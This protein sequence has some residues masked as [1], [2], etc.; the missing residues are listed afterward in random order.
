M[1]AKDQVKSILEQMS[2]D[3]TIEDIQY[4][5]YVIQTVERRLVEAETTEGVPHDAVKA[6][7]TTWRQRQSGTSRRF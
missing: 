7:L 1:S 6:R 5:L 3:C 2:D 4:R